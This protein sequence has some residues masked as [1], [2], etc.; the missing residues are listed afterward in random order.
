MEFGILLRLFGVENLI[1]TLYLS[2]KYSC[3][4]SKE[5]KKP[6][7]IDLRSDIYR[8]ISFKLGF[9]IT[10]TKLYILISLDYLDL[11]SRSQLYEE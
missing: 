6:S 1:L 7:D 5:K 8:P 10:T 11:H 4:F 9:M 2:I 3:D